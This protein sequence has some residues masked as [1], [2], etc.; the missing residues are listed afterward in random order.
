M[1]WHDRVRKAKVQVLEFQGLY[2]PQDSPGQNTGVG[3]LSLLQRI[4]PTQESNRGLPLCRR[5]LYQLS[6]RY[7]DTL[8]VDRCCGPHW[9]S[10]Q[11]RAFCFSLN[12][13]ALPLPSFPA[14]SV[15]KTPP[16]NA[17]DAGDLGSIS[18]LGRSPGGGPGSQLQCSCWEIP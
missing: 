4:L 16:A 13:A 8:N 14:G 7:T 2:S 9:A 5:I 6:Y 10:G 15:V 12:P 3:S 1:L 17:G 11:F 18:G